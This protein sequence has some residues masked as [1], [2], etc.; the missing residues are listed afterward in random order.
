[1][2]TTGTM[3]CATTAAPAGPRKET[4][5][6]NNQVNALARDCGRQ[7]IQSRS[8]EARTLQDRAAE[9]LRCDWSVGVCRLG[10]AISSV[11][12]RFSLPNAAISFGSRT[13]KV[14]P[15]PTS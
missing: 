8:A 5:I 9:T 4:V 11:D 14:L 2:T 15:R 10:R 7:H 6:F 13:V 1:M 3:N 12:L